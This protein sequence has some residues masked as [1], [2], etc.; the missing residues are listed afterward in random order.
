MSDTQ[1]ST[2]STPSVE[3]QTNGAEIRVKENGNVASCSC[4]VQRPCA[5]RNVG[6]LGSST[7]S[8]SRFPAPETG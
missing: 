8:T 7:S 4:S 5:R 3:D 2:A 1:K 6:I